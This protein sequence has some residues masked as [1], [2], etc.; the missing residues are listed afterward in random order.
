[1]EKSIL[2]IVLCMALVSGPVIQLKCQTDEQLFQNGLQKE[3]G[4]G[5]LPEAIELYKS[6]LSIDDANRELKAKALLHIGS[7]YQK[8]GNKEA[9]DAYQRIINEYGEQKEIVE[10]A[11]SRLS[12]LQSPALDPEFPKS[13]F[14]QRIKSSAKG[15]HAGSISPDGKFIS[16]WDVASGNLGIEDIINSTARLLTTDGA[17]EDPVQFTI[18]S[19][20]SPDGNHI[21]YS[22]FN[23]HKT[24]EIRLTSITNPEPKIVYKNLNEE[25]YPI[26]WSSDGENLLFRRFSDSIICQL[27][28]LNLASGN[29]QIL[30]SFEDGYWMRA[31]YSPDNRLVAYDMPV[32][33]DD[34]RYDVYIISP[35]GNDEINLV[36]H[37]ANDRL[38]GWEPQ[39]GDLIFASDRSGTWDAWIQPMEN[40]AS[41]GE[42]IRIMPGIGQINPL[43]FT[44]FNALFYGIG[45][46]KYNSMIIP[47]DEYGKPDFELAQPVL[48]S[49]YEMEYS[50]D[51]RY[52][53]FL[54]EHTRPSGP[55]WYDRPLY[56]M[57]K[58]SGKQKLLIRE[59]FLAYPRWS[60]D[61]TKVLFM[62]YERSKFD[63]DGYHGG[64]YQ[65]DINNE[66]IST[67][68]LLPGNRTDEMYPWNRWVAEW[69]RG[70][71]SVYYVN[72]SGIMVKDLSSGAE[73]RLHEKKGLA[74]I[75]RLSPSGEQLLF[76][77]KA[78][79]NK[80]GS[81]YGISLQNG[82]TA[83][84]C[85]ARE[86]EQVN[87]AVW[88]CD[89]KYLF[90][91]ENY[92]QGS[93][94]W[95][96]HG[97]GGSAEKLYEFKNQ[98]AGIST[99]S[100]ENNMVISNFMQ[101]AEIWMMQNILSALKDKR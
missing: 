92:D 98:N 78:T 59:F 5:A 50:S 74:S 25:A 85:T 19:T 10:I 51:G 7:C 67:I 83:E 8:L 2:K 72:A 36:K 42:P 30:K 82:E 17:M 34:G 48:G 90:F 58:S 99:N 77:T 55:G 9:S 20:I 71:D 56:M 16:Y 14:L 31:F 49:K 6:I 27:A 64:I 43:G 12:S 1:M 53:V 91:T 65:Y 40:G 24:Y 86:A 11:R 57:D 38:L 89:G 62:G 41:S 69:S 23:L 68:L 45:S 93:A 13:I 3:V 70:G 87:S 33:R 95:M 66:A 22:W 32:V 52:V 28:S 101:E 61:G 44:N 46:R 84:V 76:A 97:E 60:D 54:E 88:S 63:D 37:P 79:Q 26:S 81:L 47:Q 94:L 18:N 15:I 35:D 75:L 4:E 73:T 96:V 100:F 39:S 80:R 29:I 21:A